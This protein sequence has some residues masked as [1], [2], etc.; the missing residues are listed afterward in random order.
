VAAPIED[1]VIAVGRLLEADW[2]A[3][4]SDDVGRK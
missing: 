3:E 4:K 1:V 2:I